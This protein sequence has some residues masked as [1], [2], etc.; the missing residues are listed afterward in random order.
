MFLEKHLNKIEISCSQIR[1]FNIVKM[2]I[3]FKLTYIFKPIST[4]IATGTFVEI[5]KLI[6]K[7]MWKC[8]GYTI[9]KQL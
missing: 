2:F 6:T 1:R 5:D 8:K 9:A 4:K 7:L 3:L